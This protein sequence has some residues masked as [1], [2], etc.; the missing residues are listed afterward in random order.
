M[1]EKKVIEVGDEISVEIE[2][3]NKVKAKVI[4]KDNDGVFIEGKFHSDS[5]FDWQKYLKNKEV[6]WNGK[7]FWYKDKD[8]KKVVEC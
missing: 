8:A 1:K 4:D 6:N 2:K 5:E 3:G 7:V